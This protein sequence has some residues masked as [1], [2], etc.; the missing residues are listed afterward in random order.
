M[1]F[2]SRLLGPVIGR[3]F[4]RWTHHAHSTTNAPVT[5]IVSGA[6]HSLEIAALSSADVAAL[7]PEQLRGIVPT[8]MVYFNTAALIGLSGAQLNVL[9]TSQFVDLL[10][11]E[12]RALS[13]QQIAWVATADL[14]A[15]RSVQAAALTSAQVGALTS[16][17]I[18]SLTTADLAVVTSDA[19]ATRRAEI[20]LQDVWAGRES[21]EFALGL[22]ALALAPG[23]VVA[24]ILGDRRRL[25]ETVFRPSRCCCGWMD[26][27]R[28]C[29]EGADLLVPSALASR[30]T[31]VS[32][33]R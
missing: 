17:Q 18:M 32:P 13:A 12:I 7:T 28:V 5:T 4:D 3:A 30:N 31:G 33:L 22:N 27:S 29:A 20:W 16:A 11:A 2:F 19:A 14:H 23:D 26:A 8:D 10:P 9:S 21:V 6:L 1:S 24:L 25:F 15:M